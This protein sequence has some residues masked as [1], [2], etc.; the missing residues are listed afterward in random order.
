M[1]RQSNPRVISVDSRPT[2]AHKVA[3]EVRYDVE[4]HVI[5]AKEASIFHEKFSMNSNNTITLLPHFL[6][7]FVKC[8]VI[9]VT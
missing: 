7:P 5:S 2:K 8:F 1:I 4:I 6:Y 9:D 3:D